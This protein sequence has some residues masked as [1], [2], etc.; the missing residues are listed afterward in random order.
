MPRPIRMTGKLSC[1]STWRFSDHSKGGSVIEREEHCIVAFAE[2]L[3]GSGEILVSPFG[4]VPRKATLL[5]RATFEPD[6]V[7][8]DGEAMALDAEGR[9]ESWLPFRFIFDLLSAGKR[10]VIMMPV[11]IDK[12]GS[13]N[14]SCIGPHEKPKVQLIGSRG[15]PGNTISHA[16]SYWVPQHSPRVFVETVDFIS[17]VGKPL[18]HVRSVVSNL[19]VFDF[20]GD[21]MRLASLHPGVTV[22]EVQENTGFEVEIADNLATTRDPTDEELRLIREV[23]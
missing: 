17:G 1:P 10:H 9:V 20:A 8:S 5:A 21:R 7:L 18:G 15:A 14:I 22:D 16:T 23:L 13:M 11:Q 12:A 6:L 3:R 19:G 4:D 2:I